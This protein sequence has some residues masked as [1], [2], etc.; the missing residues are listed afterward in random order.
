VYIAGCEC[1]RCWREARFREASGGGFS[2]ADGVWYHLGSAGLAE[3]PGLELPL[4]S[5]ASVAEAEASHFISH[6]E[7][8]TFF[9]ERG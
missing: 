7:Q 3:E 4:A 6:P 1:E 8:L 5:S 9:H 2:A